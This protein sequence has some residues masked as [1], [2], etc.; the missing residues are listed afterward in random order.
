MG[1]QVGLLWAASIFV[2]GT[3]LDRVLAEPSQDLRARTAACIGGDSFARI[4]ALERG[5]FMAPLDSGASLIGM[6]P[7]DVVAAP[8]HRNNAG[9]LAM[10][11]FFLAPP[12]R[13]RTIAAEWDVDYVAICPSSFT[14]I[15]LAREGPGGLALGLREGRAPRWLEPVPLGDGTLRVWRVKRAP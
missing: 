14:E 10:Y 6:T 13:A 8:Y 9:N 2:A 15:D 4:A 3:L 7:H 1:G 12:E 5:R 11:R